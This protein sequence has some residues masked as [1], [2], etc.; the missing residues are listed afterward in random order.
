MLLTNNPIPR[1]IASV[2]QE[3]GQCGHGC[4]MCEQPLHYCMQR[5]RGL[6]PPQGLRT[7]WPSQRS[8]QAPTGSRLGG[9]SGA[10]RGTEIH[11]Q[12]LSISRE[13]RARTLALLG[14]RVSRAS[15]LGSHSHCLIRTELPWAARQA[16]GRLLLEQLLS[17]AE[18]LT[19]LAST[20][21]FQSVE[22]NLWWGVAGDWPLLLAPVDGLATNEIKQNCKMYS[23]NPKEGRKGNKE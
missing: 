7:S 15:W 5:E 2:L 16:L 9:V 14:T 17:G 6:L 8:S 12:C 20:S 1:A 4:E 11:L 10:V 23:I 18:S 22:G 3:P 21:G 13:A 19:T